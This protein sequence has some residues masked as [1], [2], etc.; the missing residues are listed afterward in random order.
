MKIPLRKVFKLLL[1][2]INFLL[3]YISKK[4]SG[5]NAE[6]TKADTGKFMS[7]SNHSFDAHVILLSFSL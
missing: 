5:T 7:K 6:F 2:F 4:Y 3:S 1:D